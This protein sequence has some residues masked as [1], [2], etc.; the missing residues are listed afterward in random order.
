MASLGSPGSWAP[1]WPT[2]GY[3]GRSLPTGC[4]PPRGRR[5]SFTTEASPGST[6]LTWGR[7]C[8][9]ATPASGLAPR[10]SRPSRSRSGSKTRT[11]SR[12]GGLEASASTPAPPGASSDLGPQWIV[13]QGSPVCWGALRNLGGPA[14]ICAGERGVRR[15]PGSPT[16]RKGIFIFFVG[17]KRSLRAPDNLLP[18]PG[19]SP[20]HR[21]LD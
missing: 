7:T 3:L 1:H 19:A 21:G 12:G 4:P 10:A 17:E 9:V 15:G 6:C 14:H 20:P 18:G 5:W 13:G 11:G 8:S 2:P 16:H